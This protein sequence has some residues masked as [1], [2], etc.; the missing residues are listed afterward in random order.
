MK[1]PFVLECQ[2][3]GPRLLENSQGGCKDLF[4]FELE[5]TALVCLNS[6]LGFRRDLQLS[7]QRFFGGF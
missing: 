6:L 5:Q 7:F 3:A 2:V 1:V 4:G